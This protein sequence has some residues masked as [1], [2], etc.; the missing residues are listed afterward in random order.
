MENKSENKYDNS[1]PIAFELELN[2]DEKAVV[3]ETL[4]RVENASIWVEENI[5]KELNTH[6]QIY[7]KCFF[8]LKMHFKLSTIYAKKVISKVAAS[9]KRNRSIDHN[10]LNFDTKMFFIVDNKITLKL[11]DMKNI[12]SVIPDTGGIHL[13]L[14][15]F[16]YTKGLLIR[17]QE[18]QKLIFSLMFQE[19]PK[20]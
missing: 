9:R 10:F 13:A 3:E 16:K 19:I 2:P 17:D 6:S 18:S 20:D 7:N 1:R 8:P 12:T 4:S 5:E 14:Q 15:E 11:L